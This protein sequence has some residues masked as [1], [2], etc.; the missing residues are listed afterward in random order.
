MSQTGDQS[1]LLR[2]EV[3]RIIHSG[4]RE[5]I[6]P[7]GRPR[8]A[9]LLTLLSAAFLW[10]CFTP[11]ECAPL[12]WIALVPLLQLA[13]AAA[14]PRFSGLLT[15][16]AGFLG[17]LATLQWMRLG[18]PAMYL[19]LAA[20]A[21][22][23]ACYLPVFIWIVR[24]SAYRRIPLWLAA[25]VAWTSLE[26]LRAHLLTGFSWYY[27]GHSQYQ[28]TSLIQISDVTGAWGLSFLMAWFSGLAADFIPAHWLQRLGL[29]I[30]VS[31]PRPR[32][33]PWAAFAIV[34][35]GCW[36]YGSVRQMPPDKFPAGPV[37]A[38]I[39]GHF[40]PELKHD[41][42]LTLT[43]YR[44]HNGLMQQA[45]TLQPDLMVW[46]ETM[47]PWPE[48]SV[49]EGV[50][51]AEILAQLP[52]DVVRDFGNET[53]LL[54][55]QFRSGE[56][57]QSLS[58]HAQGTGTALMIGLE[59]IVAEKD[60]TRVYNSAAFVRPDIGYSGRY[61]KIHR[62][63]FGEYIPLKDL[64]PWLSNLTPFGAGFGID[65]GQQPQLFEYGKWRFVPLIC[66]ED[67]VPSLVRHMAAQRDASGNTG[68]LLVNLTNDGWFHGSSELDQHLITATFRC[69]ENRIPM[70][71]AVNGG[72][73]AFIDGDGRIREPAT[74]KVM[75]EPF[76]GVHPELADVQSLRDPETGR[77]RRNFSGIILGQV[78]L[79][80]RTS[81]YTVYGDWFPCI[82]CAIAAFG[83]IYRRR[84]T[85][86]S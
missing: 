24:R 19:A 6:R 63:I 67:T 5:E 3:L 57:Q 8:A 1:P 30:A 26:Y 60:S 12:G 61:D 50:T 32:I 16:L 25:P 54:I 72:I 49:A 51:D 81:L 70:V 45:V 65:A 80:P 20:L 17:A 34:F 48:R 75:Q 84:S 39:Q 66:F 69:V 58:S 21:A 10:A 33:V 7:V 35:A 46:P 82:C 86:V 41:R 73:S 38:L 31:T 71:R 15:W 55:D 62:V 9:F 23:V 22:Y 37:V 64:F 78:P 29:E 42:E 79:D 43:R 74:I 4:R 18:H 13:R 36:T 44:V 53:Q 2:P 83:F 47:F 59:A 52:L 14:L 28:W 77:W 76:E 27:L 40:P 56:V 68:D 85:A 11:L